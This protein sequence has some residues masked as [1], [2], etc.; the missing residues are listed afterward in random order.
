M[1][2]IATKQRPALLHLFIYSVSVI[3]TLFGCGCLSIPRIVLR[4]CSHQLSGDTEPLRGGVG[5]RAAN[6][7][8]SVLYTETAVIAAEGR[9]WY[10][11]G[12]VTWQQIISVTLWDVIERW[13][14][15]YIQAAWFG[16]QMPSLW[17]ASIVICSYLAIAIPHSL[18]RLQLA[19]SA[20]LGANN[21]VNCQA[22]HETRP[23]QQESDS[24]ALSSKASCRPRCLLSLSLYT[25]QRDV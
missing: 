1:H 6:R 2:L 5:G 25:Q 4:A 11:L 15:S 23:L 19:K 18:D 12:K 17:L 16:Y 21:W 20:N 24:V 3:S 8:P 9:G 22:T 14:V 13:G 10:D 7:R